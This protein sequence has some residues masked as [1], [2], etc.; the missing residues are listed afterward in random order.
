MRCY[1]CDTLMR[2]ARKVKL[3]PWREMEVPPTS[4]DDL[5]YLFY[6][7]E[8]SYRWAFICQPCYRK[9]DNEV[10][11]AEIGCMTFN[12]AGASR[13]DKAALVDEAKYQAFQRQQAEAMGLAD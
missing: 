4:P 3:R 8:M 11:L 7:K 13:G 1:Y 2:L 5:A 12:L 10:G 6:C 9:L